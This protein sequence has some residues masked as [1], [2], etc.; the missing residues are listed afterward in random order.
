MKARRGVTRLESLI[1]AVCKPAGGRIHRYSYLS[2]ALDR[3]PG[4]GLDEGMPGLGSLTRT[5]EELNR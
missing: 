3:G 5:Q 1:A 2:P 4:L